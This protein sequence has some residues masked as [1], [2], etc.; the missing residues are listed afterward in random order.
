MKYFCLFLL[1]LLIFGCNSS[2]NNS[3]QS[4]QATTEQTQSTVNVVN[5]DDENSCL[6]YLKGKAFYG[7]NVKLDFSQDENVSVYNKTTGELAFGGSVTIGSRYGNASRKIEIS[8]VD[9]NGT[10]KLVLGSDGKLMD[11]T[12]FTI[13]KP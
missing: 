11:E 1:F 8:S 6:N 5:V 12:D 3:T 2:D 4:S 9:G 7:G 13:Y 10:L